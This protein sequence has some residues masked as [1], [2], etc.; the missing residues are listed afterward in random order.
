[1]AVLSVVL[2]PQ[3]SFATYVSADFGTGKYLNLKVD[4]TETKDW[5]GSL[6]LNVSGSKS[7]ALCVDLFTSMSVNQIYGTN[8]GTP[9]QINNGGRVAWLLDYELPQLNRAASLAG[10]QRAIW[11]IVHDNGNGFSSGRIQASTLHPTGAAAF[12][13]AK[14]LLVLSAGNFAAGGTVYFNHELS[15]GH[16]VK[17]LMGAGP[18]NIPIQLSGI[19]EPQTSAMLAMGGLTGLMLKRR[20]K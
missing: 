20:R 11:D 17:T 19:P 16:N 3:K 8:F 6:N 12:N 14:A 13:E 10:L 5:A 7:T 2:F 18:N 9:S 15:N 1:M 4:G